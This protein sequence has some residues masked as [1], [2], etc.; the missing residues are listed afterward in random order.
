ML[1]NL[2]SSARG[3]VGG[4]ARPGS[5]VSS[6][7]SISSDKLKMVMLELENAF[8]ELSESHL[9]LSKAVAETEDGQIT[10]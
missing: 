9:E 7:S 1:S 8:K 4:A 3:A 6:L 5:A 2:A 10:G